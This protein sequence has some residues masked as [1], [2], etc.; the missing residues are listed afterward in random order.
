MTDLSADNFD[1]TSFQNHKWNIWHHNLAKFFIYVMVH[2]KIDKKS[3]AQFCCP[4]I[5]QKSRPYG[6]AGRSETI[7]RHFEVRMMAT[8]RLV[9]SL[10]IAT[11]HFSWSRWSSCIFEGFWKFERLRWWIKSPFVAK[12]IKS[13]AHFFVL[14]FLKEYTLWQSGNKM[15]SY[16]VT[17]KFRY[18][19]KTSQILPLVFFGH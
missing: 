2:S 15:K 3:L 18:W 6:K 9:M 11:S 7:W 12:L 1:R 5:F 4:I 14:S 13:V 17:L 8:C 16:E 10:L 19:Q